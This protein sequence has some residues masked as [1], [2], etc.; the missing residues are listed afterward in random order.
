MKPVNLGILVLPLLMLFSM[1]TYALNQD[2][3][4]KKNNLK[5]LYAMSLSELMQVKVRT[6][7]TLTHSNKYYSPAALTV[8]TQK[9]IKGSGA[10]TLNELLQIYVPGLQL[11]KHHYGHSHIG[12]RGF[13]SGEDNYFITVNGHAI[14]KRSVTGG[15]A[16]RDLMLLADIKQIDVIRGPGSAIYGFGAE[17]MVI[18]ITTFDGNTFNGTEVRTR[19]GLGT[20]RY[21]I[22][23][24][25]GG[26]FGKKGAYFLYGGFSHV[27]G[28]SLEDS[29]YIFGR[30]FTAKDS[31]LVE[32][33]EPT[34]TLIPREGAAYRDMPPIKLHAQLTWK[35][36]QAHVRYTRGGEKLANRI[37]RVAPPP[38]GNDAPLTDQEGQ[39]GYQQVSAH[40]DYK[41]EFFDSWMLEYA[42]GYDMSDYEKLSLNLPIIE[43]RQFSH[44]EDTYFSRAII[45]W[46]PSD[47]ISLAA[48]YEYN[49]NEY[50]LWSPYFPDKAP[51]SGRFKEGMPRWNTQIHSM[52]AEF[53][54][55]INEQWTTFSSARID[56]HSFS[57]FE[58]SPRF[59]L[60]AIPTEKDAVKIILSRSNLL[61]YADN[62][63]LMYHDG[64]ENINTETLD[65]IEVR[66]ERKHSS[67]IFTAISAYYQH[68][69]AVGWDVAR[70]KSTIVGEQDQA[71]GE[72]ELSY[73]GGTFQLGLSHL[74]HKLINF[75]LG[76]SAK[77][78]YVTAAPFG[79]GNNLDSWSNNI[80]KI[81]GSLTLSDQWRIHGNLQYLWGFE[82]VKDQIAYR[83]SIAPEGAQVTDPGWEDTFEKSIFLNLGVAYMPINKLTFNLIGYH[84]LGLIDENLNKQIYLGG[85]G[86]YRNLAP[87]IGLD[88][89]WEF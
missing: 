89:Q 21:S 46:T 27:P 62:V 78:T 5:R 29:P 39:V 45:H 4:S 40:I 50:G 49:R 30:S 74:Y 19:A 9:D 69:N 33:G 24:K 37:L 83:N 54:W 26:S 57:D 65:N 8:I 36:L 68:I 67:K 73:K 51:T 48:G 60:V 43:T 22:E 58:I 87:S 81:D 86:G 20:E 44:R 7:A 59:A 18:A 55:H 80:T 28:A 85:F 3:Y 76:E 71:G 70:Q 23:T 53:Q 16:E 56:K 52:L 75:K 6:A 1:P 2:D 82:G 63:Y 88:A 13:I 14:S 38:I 15:I 77:S 61:T 32:A 10:R 41:R 25:H 79:F 35:D 31:T 64:S 84:L 47:Q 42:I 11:A 34:E 12:T 17:S 72:W 66:Y